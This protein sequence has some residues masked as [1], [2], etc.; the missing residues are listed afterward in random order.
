MHSTYQAILFIAFHVYFLSRISL[1][2]EPVPAPES[3][4]F[5][6]SPQVGPCQQCLM[7]CRGQANNPP[8][9][10]DI[11]VLRGW[12]YRGC[13]TDNVNDRTLI[14]KKLRGRGVTV[15]RCSYFCK[16]YQFFGVEY[17]NESVSLSLAC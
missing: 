17:S 5:A 8:N 15:E 11:A 2:Q 6:N 7:T 4:I 9:I 12:N 16:D 10:P 13:W 3:S 14:E 1:A